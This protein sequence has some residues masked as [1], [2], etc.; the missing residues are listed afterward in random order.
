V[1]LLLKRAPLLV[2]NILNLAE[3]IVVPVVEETVAARCLL[4][5]EVGGLERRF[6]GVIVGA[7]WQTQDQIFKSL[8]F[9]LG[10]VV[11]LSINEGAFRDQLGDLL[12]H[13]ERRILLLTV[14]F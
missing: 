2:K 7:L 3:D 4:L 14:D 8:H 12:P 10:P 13:E 5:L 6:D 11:N 1:L 9:V